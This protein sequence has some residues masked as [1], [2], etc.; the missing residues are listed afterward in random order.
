MTL[1][2]WPGEAGGVNA[3]RVFYKGIKMGFL[4]FLFGS[5]NSPVKPDEPFPEEF[6]I[7]VKAPFTMTTAED[8]L[9]GEVPLDAFGDSD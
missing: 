1:Q 4:S 7:A 9:S 6:D 2:Y 8:M 5:S 3:Q